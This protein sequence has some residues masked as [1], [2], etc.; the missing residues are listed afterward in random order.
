MISVGA[1]GVISVASNLLPREVSKMVNL[2]LENNFTA[3]ANED[4]KGYYSLLQDAIPALA[5]QETFGF[6]GTD[7]VFREIGFLQ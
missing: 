5:G 7:N 3:A 4:P 6:K 2:A 1:T